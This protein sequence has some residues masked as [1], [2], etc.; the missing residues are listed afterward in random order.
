MIISLRI[1]SYLVSF[2]GHSLSV[3]S[4]FSKTHFIKFAILSRYHLPSLCYS[5]FL[6]PS[7]CISISYFL[8]DSI[9][10]SLSISYSHSTSFSLSLSVFLSHSHSLT[11]YLSISI[12]SFLFAFYSLGVVPLLIV[13]TTGDRNSDL[14]SNIDDTK[15]SL[16]ILNEESLYSIADFHGIDRNQ[17]VILQSDSRAPMLDVRTANELNQ[18]IYDWIDDL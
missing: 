10:N 15:K 4:L 6:Y 13:S 18:I 9:F 14:D 16:S 17:I 2:Y 3:C 8:K 12:S 5:L 11:L 7:L 1:S